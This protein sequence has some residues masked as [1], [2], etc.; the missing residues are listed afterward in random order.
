LLDAEVFVVVHV[1]DAGHV[2]AV[3][4]DD[5]CNLCAYKQIGDW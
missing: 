1:I 3:V 5:R 2:V 4:I